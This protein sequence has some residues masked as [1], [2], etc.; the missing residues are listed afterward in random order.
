[1]TNFGSYRSNAFL[2][3]FILL[4]SL[5]CFSY[6][7]MAK[8]SKN[9]LDALEMIEKAQEF[10]ANQKLE[11]AE[12]ALSEVFKLTDDKKLLSLVYFEIAY[13]KF[14][15]GKHS[16]I[17]EQYIKKALEANPAFELQGYYDEEFKAVFKTLGGKESE[18]SRQ[19]SE[20]AY[21]ETEDLKIY[22]KKS[23]FIFPILYEK[24]IGS[25]VLTNQRKVFMNEQMQKMFVRDFKRIDFYNIKADDSIE[26]FLNDAD[27]C[28]HKNAKTILAVRMEAD[29][30]LKEAV[31]AEDDLRKTFKN[32]YAIVPFID[33][34]EKKV[35]EGEKS[36]SYVYDMYIHFDIYNTKTRQKIKTLKINNKKNVLGI[37]SSVTG[38][39][40]VDNNDLKDLP[41]E[42]RKDEE[43][44]RSSTAG[45]YAV[46]KKEI[47]SM[48]QFRIAAIISSVSH[49]KFG[50]DIGKDIGIKIDHRYK[51]YVNQA[52]GSK[53]MTAF[54]KIRK[55][56]KSF[57]EAQTLIGKPG[58]GDQVLEDPKVGIN[59][60]GGFGLVPLH[61]D[62]GD[63]VVAG[64]HKCLHLGA[65]YELGPVLGR[66]EWYTALN[67]RIGIPSPEEEYDQITI[68]QVL[69]NL[70]LVKK[71]YLRR[72]ALN[73]G[74]YI[75]IHSAKIT[76]DYFYYLE[77]EVK[78]S[79]WGL[80]LNAGAEF[81]ITPSIS[82]FGG[83]YLD[84]YSNPSKLK[85]GGS[86]ESFP[87]DWEWNARGLSLNLGVKVTL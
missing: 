8:E 59:V 49:G 60:T 71:F 16:I 37:L 76:Q 43:S 26:S 56:K 34:V 31:I 66:S 5:T 69:F 42:V 28:I 24:S 3:G 80:T 73:F 33:S 41:K 6:Y 25:G 67:L 18:A 35:V 83:F 79:S 12:S 82:A 11:E 72:M 9:D 46:L 53:K 2:V 45:L 58:E 7:S 39:L 14:L 78:G 21:T 13:V 62:L 77:N 48:P 84:F 85:S 57:S 68:S 64:S 4:F 61:I 40:Q 70:G 86:D 29:G 51:T 87:D 50:F 32:S 74:G 36:T 63:D 52:D 17:Y 15:Q 75:G 10:R 65:E 38:S 44:F 30:K 19:E 23:L 55:V 47:K 1:M 20:I 54:G 27:V 22:E 81:L